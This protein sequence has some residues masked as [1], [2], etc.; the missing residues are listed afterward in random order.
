MQ[1]ESKK[2]AKIYAAWRERELRGE[3]VGGHIRESR[4]G[5]DGATRMQ[6]RGEADKENTPENTSHDRPVTI[7]ST[8]Q[9]RF[10]VFRRRSQGVPITDSSM[11]A[12]RLAPAG[13]QST[14]TCLIIFQCSCLGVLRTPFDTRPCSAAATC[15]MPQRGRESMSHS[16]SVEKQ[17]QEELAREERITELLE[18]YKKVS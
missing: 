3:P 7:K 18:S 10:K 9:R 11:V 2:A 16:L 4:R 13:R 12:D 1:S 17:R 15:G 14:G 6:H 8:I 5:T